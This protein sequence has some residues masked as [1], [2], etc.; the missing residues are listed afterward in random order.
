ME[1]T[2]VAEKNRIAAFAETESTAADPKE[3]ASPQ[4]RRF[5]V[6]GDTLAKA[7]ADLPD[8]QRVALRWL[9]DYC[10]RQNMNVTE[11]AALL[12][13]N[14]GEPYNYHTLYAAFTGRREGHSGLDNLTDSIEKFRRRVE[15]SQ[16]RQAT[17]FI[18]TA[19]TKK[20]WSYCRRAFTQNRIGSIIG[21]SQI[22]K[23][24]AL[25]AYATAH[26][27]G[28]TRLVRMPT[29]GSLSD[30]MNEM[31]ALYN[32]APHS[33]HSDRRRRI[34]ECFDEK[35]LLIVDEC[36]Q[37]VGGSTDRALA[38]LEFV[39]EI[40]DR[41]K[42]G[43]VLCGTDVFRSEL[44]KNKVLRQLWLRGMPPLQLPVVSTQKDLDTFAREFGLTPAPDKEITISA[45]GLDGRDIKH[46]DNPARLERDVNKDF[47]LGRWVAILQ[48]ARG[49]AKERHKPMSWGY[50]IFAH[51]Q[52][53]ALGHFE[54]A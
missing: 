39:R 4:N 20:I 11:A 47:G 13:K 9:A 43:V 17:D 6:A 27:H 8:D 37:C 12:E 54:L 31:A 25:A 53:E 5:S 16:P 52:F 51:T 1:E 21:P 32:V 29:R 45:P 19:L 14:N 38:S 44:Q 3:N 35:T 42:C 50:V 24:V 41:R 28:E 46:S 7:T 22:G 26:N 36:H 40:H 23:T 10:R 30:F 15:E 48:E 18:E 49:I 2:P 33:K 34:I